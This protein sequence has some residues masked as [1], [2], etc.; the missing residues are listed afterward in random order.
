[1]R[2]IVVYESLW[3]NTAA[4][5]HAIAEGIGDD[6]EVLDTARAD[7]ATVAQADLLVAGAPVHAMNLPTEQSRANAAQRPS[8]PD[9]LAADLSHPSIRQWLEEVPRGSARAAAFDTRVRGPLGH[10]AAPRILAA[11]TDL[12]YSACVKAEGFHVDFRTT[13]S[14][15]AALLREGEIERAREWGRELRRVAG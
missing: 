10:G 2:A 8:G 7:P 3:G 12:G 1:M 15:Q 4:I 14:G 11:L 5:A 6:A 9:A 13:R